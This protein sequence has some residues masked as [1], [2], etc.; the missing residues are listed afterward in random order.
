[1][2]RDRLVVRIQDTSL[3]ERLQ[4]DPDLTLEKAKKAICQWEAVHEQQNIISGTDTPLRQSTPPAAAGTVLDHWGP[5]I[6]GSTVLRRTDW[7]T[8]VRCVFTGNRTVL[9]SVNGLLAPPVRFLWP[10]QEA[11]ASLGSV[12]NWPLIQRKAAAVCGGWIE[13]RFAG[14]PSNP[15]PQP[16]SETWWNSW[17]SPHSQH[18]PSTSNSASFSKD[19]VALERNTKS[20][21]NWM[22]HTSHSSHHAGY[23][24]HWGER[25]WTS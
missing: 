9:E 17:H 16:C 23:H 13:V 5:P 3:P 7:F 18:P 14:T 12:W 24:C 1:M 2:I 22:L 8:T 15:V 6:W 4:L 25:S 10:C 21:W 11:I 19:W 20:N